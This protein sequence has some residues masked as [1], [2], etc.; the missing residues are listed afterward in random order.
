MRAYCSLKWSVFG[1]LFTVILEKI[2]PAKEGI[3][4][5]SG[6]SEEEVMRNV[7]EAIKGY[8]KV[9]QKEHRIIPSSKHVIS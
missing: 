9:A 2:L 5:A 8:L 4:Y 1:G 7:Q 3:E 6:K